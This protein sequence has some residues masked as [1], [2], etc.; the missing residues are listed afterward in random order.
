MRR[1][2]AAA[3]RELV[4]RHA[5]D[6]FAF[7]YSLLGNHADA[8]DMVQET[9]LGA[10]RR[11]DSFEGRA[12]LRTWLGR[13]LVNRVSNLRRANR[14]RRALSLD[15]AADGKRWGRISAVGGDCRHLSPAPATSS[16]V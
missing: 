13:I 9:F 6:L 1:G 5:R 2:D 15:A 11:L 4:D 7:A 8:E 3:R 12:S 16:R 10:L 14:V